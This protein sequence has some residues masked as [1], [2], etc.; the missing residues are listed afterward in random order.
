MSNVENTRMAHERVIHAAG[1]VV[2]RKRSGS[3]RTEP[4]VELLVVHRPSYDDWTFPKGKV[5]PGEELQATAVR[6]I[7]EEAGLRVRLGIPL[8]HVS[9][10]VAAGTKVVDY[11]SARP[12]GQDDMEPF[13]PNK[14]VDEI[15]W[16]GTREAAD[17]LTYDHDREVLESFSALRERQGH[18]SRTLVVLRHAKAAARNGYADDL[19]RP[20][21]AA[22]AERARAVAPLLAAYGIRRVVSSPAVRCA[23]TVEPYAH[24]ISTFLEI[25]DRLAEDTKAAQVQ[26]SLTALLDRKSPVVLCSHRPTLPWI[27]DAIGIDTQD[28]APG[29]AIVV[30]HRKGVVLATERLST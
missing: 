3:G 8:H 23:Q 1:G 19:E 9:Y 12:V 22:G 14:E 26:R 30:H 10:A 4:G 7:A 13:V 11:W 25:D 2:W 24:S 27:F 18:R 29:E 21:T 6:E 20:L 16:V 5:D 28:L 15:R 17:L